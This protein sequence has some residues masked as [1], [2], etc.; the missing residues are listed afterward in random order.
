VGAAG[1]LLGFVEA[2]LH[3]DAELLGELLH[4]PP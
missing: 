4:G 2:A 1:A 3:L